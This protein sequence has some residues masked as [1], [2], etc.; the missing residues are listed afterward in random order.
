MRIR[1]TL[2]PHQRGAKQLLAQYG[3]RLVCVRYR[4]DEQNKKRFKTVELIVEERAWDP[5]AGKWQADRLVPVRVTVTEFALRQQIKGVGGKWNP[6]RGV[7]EVRYDQVMALGLTD[8][9]VED[10]ESI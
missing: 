2:H 10:R 5:A 3:S 1:L 8:R 6:Q 7:W 4:Y 9:I